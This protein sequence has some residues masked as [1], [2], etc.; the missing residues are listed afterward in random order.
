MELELRNPIDNLLIRIEKLLSDQN[1][2][3]DQQ[4]FLYS[5][6]DLLKTYRTNPG[7]FSD[8]LLK[9]KELEKDVQK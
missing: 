5:I 1:I 7:T 8:L 9:V 6:K 2:Q 4:N 3:P